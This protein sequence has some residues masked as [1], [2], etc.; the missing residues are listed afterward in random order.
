MSA[1]IPPTPRERGRSLIAHIAIG[2]GLTVDQIIAHDRRFA[3]VQARKKVVHALRNEGWTFRR[4]GNALE[5]DWS[6]VRDLYQR[7]SMG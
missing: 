4:I 5:R 1:A 3:I 7:K 6:T 2:Q